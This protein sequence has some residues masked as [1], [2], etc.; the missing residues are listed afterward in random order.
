MVD[1]SPK[2]PNAI[3]NSTQNAQSNSTDKD[4]GPEKNVGD[5][6][7]Q[8][9]STSAIELT[10][11]P[12]E[13]PKKIVKE[14]NILEPKAASA[15]SSSSVKKILNSS[16]AARDNFVKPLIHQN[17]LN[18]EKSS[19]DG[20]LSKPTKCAEA[21]AIIPIPSTLK[22]ELNSPENNVTKKI[23]VPIKAKEN[24]SDLLPSGIVL[25]K[26]RRQTVAEGLAKLKQSISVPV[27]IESG[28]VMMKNNSHTLVESTSKPSASGTTTT[29]SVQRMQKPSAANISSTMTQ[30]PSKAQQ[31]PLLATT[32]E[33][34][35]RPFKDFRI[36]CM[37]CEQTFR[38]VGWYSKHLRVIHADV[39]TSNVNL[40]SEFG[41]RIDEIIALPCDRQS[42]ALQW[43]LEKTNKI[44]TVASDTKLCVSESMLFTRHISEKQQNYMLHLRDLLIKKQNIFKHITETIKRK[45]DTLQKAQ[46]DIQ[47]LL[48]M[49]DR[50]QFLVNPTAPP[51]P[52][53]ATTTLDKNENND[54]K[55]A[56]T[57]MI[58]NHNNV[59]GAKRP[60]ITVRRMTTAVAAA[61]PERRTT[62]TATA[63]APSNTIIY[64]LNFANKDKQLKSPPPATVVQQKI[65]KPVLKHDS[66]KWP[67]KKGGGG[68][69]GLPSMPKAINKFPKSSSPVKRIKQEEEEEEDTYILPHRIEIKQEPNMEVEFIDKSSST[70]QQQQQTIIPDDEEQEIFEIMDVVDLDDD[71]DENEE[72]VDGNLMVDVNN[73]E[74]DFDDAAEL[75][76]DE[77]YYTTDGEEDFEEGQHV[78]LELVGDGS[79]GNK[80]VRVDRQQTPVK[81]GIPM[82]SHNS[83]Y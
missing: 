68:G 7:L 57:E 53:P 50:A 83:K 51:Q 75:N 15:S 9:K 1:R 13:I 21:K 80:Y 67:I 43:L 79:N 61:A 25:K 39:E 5:K 10:T 38:F 28:T 34:S 40:H 49:C 66:I 63:T 11:T 76:S 16:F 62:A 19:S 18:K 78:L 35:T 48:N 24:P 42:M 4:K 3:K 23:A 52:P 32:E 6:K 33:E 17:I 71:D 81:D 12:K 44:V 69:G 30:Q 41:T 8:T 36:P 72:L 65:V 31:Q 59:L 22:R 82:K 54:N 20:N 77:E 27:K 70:Q 60:G 47:M 56:S 55:S 14:T 26:V 37:F 64:N 46:N 45:Q 58:S 2:E 29:T 73:Q 74:S